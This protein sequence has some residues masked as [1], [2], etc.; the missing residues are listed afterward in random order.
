M[1]TKTA[2]DAPFNVC[3]SIA[4]S[5]YGER[6]PI[7]VKLSFDDKKE[8]QLLFVDG[9]SKH[10]MSVAKLYAAVRVEVDDAIMGLT[11]CR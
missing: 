11:L 2:H 3:I 7:H 5:S 8:R 6:R 10:C 4:S 9:D 1:L